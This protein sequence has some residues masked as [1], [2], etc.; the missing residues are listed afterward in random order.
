VWLPDDDLLCD[1]TLVS[2]M[3]A[4][5]A[6]LGLDMA[7]PALTQD[8]YYSHPITMQ[9]PQFQLRFTNFI[10]IM[11]PVFSRRFLALVS[12]TIGGNLSGWGLDGLWPRMSGLGRLAIIDDT[13]V[14]HT[15][16]IKHGNYA[17]NQAA[18]IPAIAEDWMVS[19]AAFVETPADY[20][21][22]LGGLLQSGDAVTIGAQFG[23]I[24]R[25]LRALLESLRDSPVSAWQLSRYLSNHLNFSIDPRPRYPRETIRAVLNEVLGRRGL[26]FPAFTP[27]A[28]PNAAPVVA[29][30]RAPVTA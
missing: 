10:E 2:R 27:N 7:Q 5:C 3:F 30:A 13:P 17:A 22:N 6:D 4:I 28:A 26:A 12:P 15:L 24:E 8:S 20:H 14:R 18:G 1:P 29:S 21:L 11:A 9:H 19:A 25:M 23:E 16:P